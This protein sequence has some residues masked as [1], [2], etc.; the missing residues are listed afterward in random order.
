[1]SGTASSNIVSGDRVSEADIPI[2]SPQWSEWLGQQS[3]FRYEGSQTNFTCNRRPNGKWYGVKKVHS[4]DKGSVPVALYIGSDL[5]CTLAKLQ[6]VH[7]RFSMDNWDF[8]RWYHSPER[9]GKKK[10]IPGGY[11]KKPPCTTDGGST[12]T[13]TQSS[14]ASLKEEIRRLG[15]ELNL[16]K[17]MRDT[18]QSKYAKAVEDNGR[19]I[20]LAREAQAEIERLQSSSNSPDPATILNRLRKE[21]KKS[22][23]DLKDVELIIELLQAIAL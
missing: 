4:S 3:S 11:T 9:K 5:D 7:E 18:A 1:M 21:R 16:V 14:E 2:D 22:K 6:E 19:L 10:Q 23:A 8:W 13:I 20:R 17:Q 12:E 15:A